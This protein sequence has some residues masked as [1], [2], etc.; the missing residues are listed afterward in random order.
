MGTCQSPIPR[1]RLY[2]TTIRLLTNRPI[3][4]T[5]K[6]ISDETGLP[7]GWLLSIVS[8]PHVRPSVDRVECLYSYLT[9]KSLEL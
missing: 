7:E 9:G 3:T 5:L 8:R 1:S 6:Q 2:E 4:L